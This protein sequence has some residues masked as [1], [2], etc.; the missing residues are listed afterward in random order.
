MGPALATA[1]GSA[2]PEATTRPRPRRSAPER[3]PRPRLGR[4]ATSPLGQPSGRTGGATSGP[5]EGR[6]GPDRCQLA[7]KRSKDC[8]GRPAW[9]TIVAPRPDLPRSS[10]HSR[11][12]PA[13]P[14]SRWSIAASRALR[15]GGP[16]LLRH[17]PPGTRSRPVPDRRPTGDVR[18][19]QNAASASHGCATS[20]TCNAM[21]GASATG[22]VREPHGDRD[23]RARYTPALLSAPPGPGSSDDRPAPYSRGSPAPVTSPRAFPG[24]SNHLLA[25]VAVR[26]P[27]K[28]S[29]RSTD[30]AL[31]SRGH[32]SE[33]PSPTRTPGTSEST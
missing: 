29:E 31:E 7:G 19:Q 22:N 8:S 10:T 5:E 30:F 24:T 13:A 26:A 15:R 21:P 20:T 17:T 18:G 9:S 33:T 14:R 28:R 12:F 2:H 27:R 11:A 25:R 16:V 23:A 6:A 32:R 1:T 3:R 4:P